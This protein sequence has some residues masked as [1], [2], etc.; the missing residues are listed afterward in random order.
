ML[1]SVTWLGHR[2]RHDR[3][4]MENAIMS[5]RRLMQRSSPHGGR[6]EGKG[7]GK[8]RATIRF[9]VFG[10]SDGNDTWLY[11]VVIERGQA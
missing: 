6:A 9:L 5:D 1:E 3:G 4:E 7:E 2:H 11:I 10:P 8:C